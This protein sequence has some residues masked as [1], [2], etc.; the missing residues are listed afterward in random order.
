MDDGAYDPNLASLPRRDSRASEPATA[1]LGEDAAFVLTPRATTAAA[2][3]GHA[4]H[5]SV[6]STA[7]DSVRSRSGSRGGG[8]GDGCPPS[9]ALALAL[10]LAPNLAAGSV[11]P[12]SPRL[13][14]PASPAASERLATG[15]STETG[16]ATPH[17]ATFPS[18][19]PTATAALRFDGEWGQIQDSWGRAVSV[20][21]C[22][23]VAWSFLL[24]MGGVLRLGWRGE[25]EIARED[26]PGLSERLKFESA[27]ED[28]RRAWAAEL[29]ARPDR[30]SLTRA[31]FWANP[32]FVV[33]GA[34]FSFLQGLISSVGRPLV[35]RTLV[36][37]VQ[38]STMTPSY[39][40]ELICVFG[41]VSFFEGYFAVLGREVLA[42]SFSTRFMQ[43]TSALLA[44]KVRRVEFQRESPG[45]SETSLLSNDMARA[46]EYLRA[47]SSLP[48]GLASVAGGVVVLAVTV[49]ASALSGLFIMLGIL[50]LN[51]FVSNASFRLEKRNLALADERLA[52]VSSIVECARAVKLFGW[53]V[54]FLSRINQ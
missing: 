13:G 16:T 34:L 20:D 41:V 32:R 4:H 15:P 33:W 54:R 51:L 22:G 25:R 21:R 14:C 5:A 37:G 40:V 43:G 53:E 48:M 19:T 23:Y 36:R 10:A 17:K 1:G 52:V 11:T 38:L 9:R 30:P 6:A 35:V 46:N 42:E 29:R 18:D 49:G 50:L 12:E 39:A 24:F 26:L 2:N 7:T 28:T 3:P 31:L 47:A 44:D 45:P 27:G 8:D